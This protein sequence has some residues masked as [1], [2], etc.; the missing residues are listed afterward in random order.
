MKSFTL[1]ALSLSLLIISC[2]KEFQNQ[3]PGS[4]SLQ[5][6]ITDKSITTN[7]ALHFTPTLT[8][9][10]ASLA[11]DPLT[12]SITGLPQGA[13]VTPT[14]NI[15]NGSSGLPTFLISPNNIKAGTYQ[16]QFNI[17]SASGSAYN[18]PFNLNVLPA[19]NCASA[20]NY[21]H[22]YY[23]N[24]D[25]CA[26]VSSYNVQV[27]SISN[28]PNV[29]TIS[30]FMNQGTT[31]KLMVYFECGNVNSGN[32]EMYLYVPKQTLNTNYTVSGWGYYYA[33][34]NEIYLYDTVINNGVVN[35]SCNLYLY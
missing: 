23:V 9:N 10:N 28:T 22:S 26:T 27:D 16:L 5:A 21:N 30:N 7:S 12:L 17:N 33:N 31:T 24:N 2:N 3:T 29:F 11:K 35:T 8:I 6:S 25:N 14:N 1:I 4:M 20:I 32:S 34:Y 13:T 18:F 19:A 15:L